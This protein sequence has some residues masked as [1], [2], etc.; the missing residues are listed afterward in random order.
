[1]LSLFSV[2]HSFQAIDTLQ[3]GYSVLGRALTCDAD[4]TSLV[5]NLRGKLYKRYGQDD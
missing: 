4:L 2:H 5:T 1:M 3:G